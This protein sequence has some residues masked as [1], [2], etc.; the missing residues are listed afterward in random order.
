VPA[1]LVFISR[2]EI[3]GYIPG[4]LTNLKNACIY[5]LYLT[6]AAIMK[7]YTI[8]WRSSREDILQI[9]YHDNISWVDILNAHLEAEKTVNATP[10]N[11]V[12]FNESYRYAIDNVQISTIKEL[13]FNKIPRVPKNLKGI[14]VLIP[15]AQK[16]M[17]ATGIEILADI[18]Y[19]HKFIRVVDTY[20]EAEMLLNEK[21]G[22]QG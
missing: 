16:A 17:L 19:G 20:E 14:I 1:L 9:T 8:D 15:H 5:T 4:R 12:I 22:K 11:V 10:H 6:Q 7:K 2:F 3:T 13:L 18:Q 21:L